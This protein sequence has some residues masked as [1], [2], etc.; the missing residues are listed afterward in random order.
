M[1]MDLL[2]PQERE[3]VLM[4][5]TQFRIQYE[6]SD[7]EDI[8]SYQQIMDYLDD[9][10]RNE[11]VWK[12]RH[13]VSHEG[14]LTKQKDKSYNGSA[15]NVMIEWENGEITAGTTLCAGHR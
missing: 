14:P 8:I 1:Y 7:V 4:K 2:S 12:F 3:D 13:I 15:Y 5:H 9:D 10:T 6:Q 11:H